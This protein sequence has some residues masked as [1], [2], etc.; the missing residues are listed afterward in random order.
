MSLLNLPS[1]T[2][3]TNLW[4]W[5]PFHVPLRP[6]LFRLATRMTLFAALS[7]IKGMVHDGRWSGRERACDC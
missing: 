6:F 3:P 4:P 1:E 5:P 7:K 2:G